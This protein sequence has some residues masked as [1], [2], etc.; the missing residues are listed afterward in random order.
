MITF[1]TKHSDYNSLKVWQSVAQNSKH[2]LLVHY[3]EI[4]LPTIFICISYILEFLTLS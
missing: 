2:F 4:E 1:E 3:C